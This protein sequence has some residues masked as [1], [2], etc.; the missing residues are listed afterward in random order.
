MQYLKT[1]WIAKSNS[2]L[3]RTITYSELGDDRWEKR[4][5]EF[6]HNGQIGIATDS[7]ESTNPDVGLAEICYPEIEEIEACSDDEDTFSAS[8]ILQ[9][10]FE[11]LWAKFAVPLLLKNEGRHFKDGQLIR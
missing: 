8:Y 10:E 11:E 2:K 4:R 7:F 9:D 5:I 3:E 6:F 1:I